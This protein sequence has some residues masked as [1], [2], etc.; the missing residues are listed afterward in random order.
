MLSKEF[1]EAGYKNALE[2]DP[3][4]LLNPSHRSR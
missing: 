1:A 2:G 3:N 4:S